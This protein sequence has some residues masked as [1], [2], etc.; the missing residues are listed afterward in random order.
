MTSSKT[1]DLFRFWIET[2]AR[3]RTIGAVGATHFDRGSME[4]R[5]IGASEMGV[6]WYTV[7]G[8]LDGRLLVWETM[9]M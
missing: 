7:E 4:M 9:A 5:R 6:R 3:V 8:A 2:P 1:V